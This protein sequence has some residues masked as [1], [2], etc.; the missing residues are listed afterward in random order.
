MRKKLLDNATRKTESFNSL[1]AQTIKSEKRHKKQKD[2]A[3]KKMF[4]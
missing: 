4:R 3:N 1:K 2:V